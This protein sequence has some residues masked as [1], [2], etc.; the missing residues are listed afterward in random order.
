[1]HKSATKCN[2]TVGKWCKNKHGASK[3]IDMSETYQASSQELP[4]RRR[5][6]SQEPFQEEKGRS[7]RAA[8][9]APTTSNSSKPYQEPDHI[10][11]L[12]PTGDYSC[13]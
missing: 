12:P 8:T 5:A 3:I 10:S 13:K 7:A 2:K 11:H 1:M 9:P 6:S 4:R